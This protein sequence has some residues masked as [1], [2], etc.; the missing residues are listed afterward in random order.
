MKPIFCRILIEAP[1]CKILVEAETERKAAEA[2]EA[3]LRLCRGRT[4]SISIQIECIDGPA[5]DRILNYLSDLA[6]ELE[7][8]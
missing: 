2:A 3:S 1:E 5:G 8:I 7:H 6:D 4:L